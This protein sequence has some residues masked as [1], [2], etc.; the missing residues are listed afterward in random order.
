MLGWEDSSRVPESDK[1][2]EMR[3]MKGQRVSINQ[4]K[5]GARG[6]M[7]SYT[8]TYFFKQLKNIS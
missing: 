4:K 2:R 6:Y 7:K 3:K 1:A 8:E 5:E